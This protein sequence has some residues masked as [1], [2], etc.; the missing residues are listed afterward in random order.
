METACRSWFG[1][2][3]SDTEAHA[4]LRDEYERRLTDIDKALVHDV[5]RD[6]E[7]DVTFLKRTYIAKSND[8]VTKLGQKSTSEEK[9][10]VYSI[11]H[12]CG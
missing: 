6:F 2:E 9:L 7:D 3:A 8:Y 12:L 4:A 5:I 10:K 1:D 11:I